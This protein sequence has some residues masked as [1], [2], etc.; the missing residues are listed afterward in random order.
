MIDWRR[1]GW[2]GSIN[3]WVQL[4]VKEQFR[5]NAVAR[6]ARYGRLHRLLRAFFAFNNF[7]RFIAFYLFFDITLVIGELICAH[8]TPHWIPEWTASGPAPQPDIKTI[9]L[10]V[11]SYLITAQVG[12]LGLISLAL[13]LV[14]LIAQRE[15]S[16][17]DVKLYYHESLSFE[18]VA[19]CV[20]LLAVM[21]AQLLWPLQ[22]ILHKLEFGTNLQAFKLI[23]LGVHSAWLLTNLAG[24]AHFIA[25][26]FNFVQQSAREELRERYTANVVLPLEME[27]RLRR[28]LYA[29]ETRSLLGP[30]EFDNDP[31]SCAF[32]FDF[33]IPH[34]AEMETTFAHQMA[35][36]DVRMTWVRWVL[37]RWAARCDRGAVASSRS[38]A[39]GRQGP[40]IWFTPHIDEV[41]G[42]SVSWCRRRDGVSL[43]RFER[44]V[45]R[46]AFRFRRVNDEE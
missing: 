25:T 15:N 45:L 23:L 9:I 44:W 3:R 7:G 6:R 24:L 2:T 33:G 12:V 38:R 43:T 19:S 39:L 1:G 8:F 27:A 40:L 20:A 34:V 29:V 30:D 5:E 17:T 36:Y 13:A 37:Q 31:P 14:T 22:F 41:L 32:G 4:E 11:S 42:G 10:N 35:L 46:R 18:V 16:S 21:C 26:T 28:H